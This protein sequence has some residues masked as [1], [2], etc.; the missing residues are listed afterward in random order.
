LRIAVVTAV[1]L[2]LAIAV[3]P[4]RPVERVPLP[5]AI[6]IGAFSGL[7]LFST[8]AGRVPR[9]HVGATA[10]VLV[11]RAGFFGLWA[12]NEEVVWRRVVLG[13]LLGSGVVP[14]L[15]A[16]TVGFAL[17]HRTRRCLHLCTGGIFGLLYVATGVLASSIAAHWAYN[18]LVAD[19]VDRDRLRA[20]APP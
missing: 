13:E 5:A 18:V 6:A 2:A 9:V 3:E 14:A 15:A 12:A 20:E 17:V 4:P 7:I 11:A 10:L 16:S 19:I 1:S 8:L